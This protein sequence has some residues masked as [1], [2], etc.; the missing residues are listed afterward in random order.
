MSTWNL[1]NF[2]HSE[3]I[4]MFS[5]RTH[6]FERMSPSPLH[7]QVT[8]YSILRD[9]IFCDTQL[10]KYVDQLSKAL[11]H[12]T[13]CGVDQGRTLPAESNSFTRPEF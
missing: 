5:F 6:I 13:G 1:E 10:W 7:P 9:E 8:S 3:V 4:L 2:T 12:K 11:S